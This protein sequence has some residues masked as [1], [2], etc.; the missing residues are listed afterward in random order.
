MSNVVSMQPYPGHPLRSLKQFAVKADSILRRYDELEK[1]ADRIEATAF[2][3][4]WSEYRRAAVLDDQERA[5][6]AWCEAAL[7][8]FDPDDNYEVEAGNHYFLKPNIVAARIAIVVGGFPNGSPSDPAVYVKVM[9]EHV[10]G[11]EG[12]SLIALDSAIWEITASMKFLPSVSEL[13][14]VVDRQNALWRRRLLA[15]HN[16][17]ETA[18]WLLAEIEKLQVETVGTRGSELS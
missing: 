17:A 11:M 6:I 3:E 14:A 8:R 4:P 5:A 9:I 13:M 12:L 2:G 10:C 15:I 18:G 1:L 7:A 16:I